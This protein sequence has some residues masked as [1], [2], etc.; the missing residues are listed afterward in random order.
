MCK[1]LAEWVSAGPRIKTD[2]RILY[3][4]DAYA[5]ASSGIENDNPEEDVI[6]LTA[7]AWDY[8]CPEDIECEDQADIDYKDTLRP[9]AHSMG[10]SS[11]FDHLE[12]C[13]TGGSVSDDWDRHDKDIT[14]QG[15]V[16]KKTVSM[17]WISETR[18]AQILVQY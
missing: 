5:I 16:A 10:S 18:E 3:L 7:F 15:I 8:M 13:L 6:I 12:T 17:R 1:S 2:S 11:Y 9:F 14:V 4:P